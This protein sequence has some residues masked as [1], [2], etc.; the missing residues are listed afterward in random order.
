MTIM[1][2]MVQILG[3]S[4]DLGLRSL[5]TVPESLVTLEQAAAMVGLVVNV[6]ITEY[7][8]T[9]DTSNLH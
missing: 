5:N 6:D 8:C 2:R 9:N 4:D 1:N 3:Y 7:M